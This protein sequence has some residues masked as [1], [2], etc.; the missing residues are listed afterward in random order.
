MPSNSTFRH[1]FGAVCVVCKYCLFKG[2][3]L[4]LKPSFSLPFSLPPVG[5]GRGVWEKR[6][7]KN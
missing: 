7:R 5:G 4:A 3:V 2:N 1:R 6:E